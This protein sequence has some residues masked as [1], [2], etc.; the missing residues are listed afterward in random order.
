MVPPSASRFGDD[1]ARDLALV[2]G[3]AA[4]R[5]QQPE[6]LGEVRITEDLPGDRRLAADVEGLHRIGVEFGAALLER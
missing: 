6:G 2:E 4:A 3:V 1:R 5:C